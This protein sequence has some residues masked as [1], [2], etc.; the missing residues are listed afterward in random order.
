MGKVCS[1]IDTERIFI[2]FPLVLRCFR[3]ISFAFR[4]SLKVLFPYAPHRSVAETV[5]RN[6][7]RLFPAARPPAQRGGVFRIPGRLHFVTQDG[8]IR[9]LFQPG[10]T[11]NLQGN[12][13]IGI[14][15][16]C[17]S[18]DKPL[19]SST[20]QRVPA[21]GSGPVPSKCIRREAAPPDR[22]FG[23]PSRPPPS[24]AAGQ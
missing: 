14:L 23:P 10:T 22:P 8:R 21:P 24:P 7:S 5:V 13:T 11:Q 3:S 15:I 2:S 12:E 9:K 18:I 4:H 6:A 1:Q 20:E 16:R 17:S 19:P